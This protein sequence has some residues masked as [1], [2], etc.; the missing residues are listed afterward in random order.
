MVGRGV[1]NGYMV[2]LYPKGSILFSVGMQELNRARLVYMHVFQWRFSSQTVLIQ[3][4][5]SMNS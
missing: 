5:I 3:I 2:Q 1:L 4:E